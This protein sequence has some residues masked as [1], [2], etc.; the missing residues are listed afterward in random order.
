MDCTYP[1][2]RGITQP[3]KQRNTMKN[4]ADSEDWK[5]LIWALADGE[6]S[7]EDKLRL[8]DILLNEPEARKLYVRNMAMESL[9]QWENSTTELV[10]EKSDSRT[11]PLVP[12]VQWLGGFARLPIAA[13][14]TL[15]VGLASY[16]ALRSIEN[17]PVL[18]DAT[19]ED[20]KSIG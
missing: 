10:E 17:S 19:I 13:A 5:R 18:A 11:A 1:R 9:L 8:D 4:Q 3:A 12:F 14:V 20:E 6:I 16:F 2:V 15:G 7:E